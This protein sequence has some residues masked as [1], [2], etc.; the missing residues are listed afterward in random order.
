[1]NAIE[2]RYEKTLTLMDKFMSLSPNHSTWAISCANHV[3]VG[4]W[5]FYN[6]Q[7]QTVYDEI[8]KDAV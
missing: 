1:M 4:N 5:K 8:V 6:S 7:N 3:Y 2:Q